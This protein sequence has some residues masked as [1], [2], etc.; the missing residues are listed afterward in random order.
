MTE[1]ASHTDARPSVWAVALFLASSAFALGSA[2]LLGFM[3]V[4]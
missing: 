4:G 3:P 2:V 1:P